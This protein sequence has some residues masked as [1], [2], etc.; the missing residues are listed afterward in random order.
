MTNE[1]ILKELEQLATKSAIA[2]RYEKGD[3]EG[4]FCVLKSERLVV[5]NKKLPSP[6]R[7]SV[8]AQ[9][10]AEVGIEE[11]YLKPAVREFIEDEL[12]KAARTES[13]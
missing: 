10:L 5:I 2:I 7:A 11:M 3:F 8:L 6:K 1:E 12:S 9:G 4:G 13:S